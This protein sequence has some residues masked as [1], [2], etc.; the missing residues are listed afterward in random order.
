MKHAGKIGIAISVGLMATLGVAAPASAI[1]I[2][3]QGECSMGS[4]WSAGIEKEYGVWDVDFEID[5]RTSD[6]TWRFLLKQNGRTVERDRS[7][8]IRD[9][10]DN[11]SEVEWN[12][13]QDD[14]AGRD[15][16]FFSAK[17]LSTGEICRTVLR[18]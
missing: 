8:A 10:D 16:F 13:I 14:T 7:K 11:Y 2:E 6:G 1:E 5:T 3:R 15:K 17:N 18:G 4:Q 12:V 9:W